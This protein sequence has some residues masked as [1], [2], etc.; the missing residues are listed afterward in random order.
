MASK[1]VAFLVTTAESA[2]AAVKDE[3][4]KIAHVAETVAASGLQV[5]LA[6]AKDS[7]LGTRAMNLL[8]AIEEKGMSVA[9][10]AAHILPML[11]DDFT[12]FEDAGGIEGVG[13]SIA[14]FAQ[15]AVVSFAAEFE[16]A[17]GLKKA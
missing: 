10:K 5:A 2:F 1:L 17:I 13:L 8:E 7:D 11:E 16:A 9:D 6:K 15:A 3:V 4:E 14:H 12:A